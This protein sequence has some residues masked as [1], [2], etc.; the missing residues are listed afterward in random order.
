MG[1][2]P[3]FVALFLC[4]V[5]LFMAAPISAQNV[6]YFSETN[7][8]LGGRFL[9]YWQAHG[10]LE[11]F[12]FPISPEVEEIVDGQPRIV[13]Y[14]ER[15]LFQFHPENGQP[16]DVLLAR[17]G[18]KSLEARGVNW[19]NFPR[20]GRRNGCRF[21][22]ETG[23]S[24]CQPFLS[25]WESSGGLPVFGLP[26]SDE[27]KEPS[28]TDGKTY[29]VQYFERNRMESHPANPAPYRM[30]LGLLGSEYY[31][32][33]QNSRPVSANPVLQRLVDLTNS[34]RQGAGLVP[35]TVSPALMTVAG[36]YSQVLASQGTISHTGPDGSNPD[37]R[38]KRAGYNRAVSAENLAAGPPGPDDVFA[39]WMGS[40]DHR[41]H[42]LDP[43]MREIGV[44]YTR[45]DGDPARLYDYWVM[46]LAVSR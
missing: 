46:E 29:V 1:V 31:N 18:I 45:Y 15:S 11:Q 30:Q 8:T 41:N 28:P 25:H 36:E 6:I 24:I 43:Q 27:L 21:F 9:E 13:Q 40:A 35:V 42:I 12:G 33:R 39:R 34:A 17:L 23:H 2:R 22:S 4:P 44:G 26:L 32:R 14:F 3:R 19:N 37:T 20:A 7:V 38:L 5:L 16:Y 10:G